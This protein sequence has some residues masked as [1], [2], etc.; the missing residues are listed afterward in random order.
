LVVINPNS[1]P[2]ESSLPD[3]QYCKAIPYLKGHNNVT[4]LGYIATEYGTRKIAE[5]LADMDKYWQ[6][7][8]ISLSRSVQPLGIDGIF[9]DQVECAGQQ[10][11]YFEELFRATRGRLWSSGR[12]GSTLSYPSV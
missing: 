5:S 1:G 6:W 7:H 11:K 2:G 12:P 9:V 4:L 10:L 8:Q 3:E